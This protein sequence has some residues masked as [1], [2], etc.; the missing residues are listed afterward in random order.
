ME[1]EEEE[2]QGGPGC[3]TIY[4]GQPVNLRPETPSHPPATSINPA[5]ILKGLCRPQ[6][7]QTRQTPG[8]G[9]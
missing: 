6:S 3:H 9:P 1:K 5:T 2:D 7:M 8:S 4:M